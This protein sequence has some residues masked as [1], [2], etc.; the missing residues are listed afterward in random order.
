[1]AR[2]RLE[3]GRGITCSSARASSTLAEESLAAGWLAALG[4]AALGLAACGGEVDGAADGTRL[5]QSSRAARALVQPCGPADSLRCRRIASSSADL[6]IGV[7]RPALNAGGL[8]AFAG[9]S[10]GVPSVLLGR[11]RGLDTVDM[12]NFGLG[13]PARVSLDTASRLAFVAAVTGSDGPLGAFASD[14]RG[15][16]LI[17]HYAPEPGG[18]LD[19]G[20]S[21]ISA[22][23][24]ALAPNG[25]LA[26]SS[27]DQQGGAPDSGAV[28]RGPA[29]GSVARVVSASDT[30]RPN[31]FGFSNVGALD[32]SSSGTITAQMQ[33]VTRCGIQNGVLVFDSAEPTL[34][35]ARHVITGLPPGLAP[36]LASSESGLVA[37]ALPGSDAT[38]MVLRCP[39]AGAFQTSFL[40]TGV[41]TAQPTAFTVAPSLSAVA[42]VSGAFASFGALDLAGDTVVF[43]ASLDDGRSGVFRGPDAELDA[44][45]VT[46]DELGGEAVTEVRL[47]QLNAAGDVALLL[48]SAA[49]R[50]VWRV[51]G[52]AP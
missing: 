8:V 40:A 35:Q 20:G 37:F 15:R 27:I 32:V 33:H 44:V 26:F 36:S 45:V 28:Y 38:V 6:N 50:S 49:G 9:D 14:R 22:A 42:D 10:S 23:A 12:N 18:G 2:E 17:I 11:G 5:E 47:G 34:E 48:T 30:S 24:L 1:M 43:E 29:R 25:T 51:S 13:Q 16:R 46:G 4:L 41:Y 31:Q 21:L 7:A 3:A 39:P 19:D 52:L